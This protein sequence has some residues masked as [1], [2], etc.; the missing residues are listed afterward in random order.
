MI[1]PFSLILVLGFL[2][3]QIST[4][5]IHA[6]GLDKNLYTSDFMIGN[7]VVSIIF[8]ESN[9]LQDPNIENWSEERKAQVLSEIMAGLDWW[10]RQNPRSKLTFTYVTETIGT[11]YEPVTRP[12]YDEALWIPE[13]MGQLGYS[14]TRWTSTRSYVNALRNQ[15]N[16]DW[17]FVI[18]MV[19]SLKDNDGKFADSFFA[20][21]YLGGPF[22]VM[23][24]DNNG[25]GIANMDVVTAHET[26]HIFNALDQYAGASS[27]YA[28]TNGY[29][30]TING[31]HV[32]AAT[33]NEPDSIMRGGIRWGLDQWTKLAIGWRDNDNNGRD[34][35]V[36]Q[37]PL[38]TLTQQ[39]QSSSDGAT[40][41]TGTAKVKVLARQGN[42]NGY[43]FTVDSIDKVE[44]RLRNNTWSTADPSDGAY[45][46]AEENF[47]INIPASQSTLGANAVISSS[48]LDVRVV[49]SFSIYLG[50]SG[51]GTSTSGTLSDA[52]AYPNPYKPHSDPNHNFGVNFTALTPG[53][54]VQVFTPSGET[55]FEKTTD[56]T[57]TAVNW[58]TIDTVNSGVYFFL[59]TDENGQ[60]K[61]GKIAVIK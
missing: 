34:D 21:S 6:I 54:K 51:T 49:T 17:G 20:Y 22:C 47:V 50:S 27:P 35:I 7:V 23:T 28:Y 46:G 12:Y 31:N 60:K 32:Y 44:Y 52:H 19:D 2:F 48:D 33:A 43:G 5:S 13:I 3:P 4:A 37:T 9:G 25:Y 42:A 11:K 61:K 29:F 15:Y 53:S 40:G 45:D 16:A 39:G 57:G 38:L 56:S 1:K 59:I 26:G 14:G 58:T 18:F 8:P 41:F 10:S 30:P 24:Y 55:I 36:D